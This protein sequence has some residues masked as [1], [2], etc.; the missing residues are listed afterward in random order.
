VRKSLWKHSRQKPIYIPK[1]Q[2][3]LREKGMKEEEE[4]EY[5]Q[6]KKKKRKECNEE[7]YSCKD[8]FCILKCKE[9][10]AWM[11]KSFYA[12]KCKWKK[13]QKLRCFSETR[14]AIDK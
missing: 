4:E 7:E 5:S 6:I 12:Y 14:A 2:V 13:K 8:K 10:T 1:Q 9:C 3:C 11:Y